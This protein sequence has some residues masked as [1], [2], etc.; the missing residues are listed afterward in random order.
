M[1]QFRLLWMLV[2]G[3][4]SAVEALLWA[5]VLATV[6]I[7]SFAIAGVEILS[8][9]QW[10]D[11]DEK[12][13]VEIHFGTVGRSMLTLIQIMTLDSWSGIARPMTMKYSWVIIYFVLFIGLCSIVLLNLVTAIIVETS[14]DGA[15]KDREAQQRWRD[16][17]M[18]KKCEMMVQLIEKSDKDKDNALSLE[19]LLTAYYADK[20]VQAIVEEI[21]GLQDLMRLFELVDEDGSG[22]LSEA[23][24]R[25]R[26]PDFRDDPIKF[27]CFE[28]HKVC[29][30][31]LQSMTATQQAVEQMEG[32]L[33]A[34][35]QA[36]DLPA[37][38]TQRKG[39]ESP[40]KQKPAVHHH[41]PGDMA[42]GRPDS[43]VAARTKPVAQDRMLKCT[44]GNLRPET[45]GAM[46]GLARMMIRVCVKLGITQDEI[47]QDLGDS[48]LRGPLAGVLA[49]QMELS[50]RPN[51]GLA[52]T[53]QALP[54]AA[55]EPW[56]GCGDN[57]IP[58]CA[59]SCRT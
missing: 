31:A 5:V 54:P 51:T 43:S 14:M 10:D 48:V 29:K 9:Q 45:V 12:E 17:E 2:R 59:T 32:N 18:A 53:V 28:S 23:E 36:L 47:L 13:L 35:L 7:Y 8:S 56:M 27:I 58:A 16:K 44:D 21:C 20:E 37:A 25:E 55:S 34:A 46:R 33:K 38:P 41:S 11:G 39:L 52:R 3:L 30:K 49:E 4:W 40:S 22:T 42:A 1:S 50:P 57:I 26:Y 6:M 24:L 15:N 19:E